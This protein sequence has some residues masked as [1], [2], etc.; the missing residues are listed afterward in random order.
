MRKKN[1]GGV[2]DLL[3]AEERFQ[4]VLE[5]A[6]RRDEAEVERL[7]NTSP[8]YRYTFIRNDLAFAERIGV[9]T[10]IAL[11]VCLMLMEILAKL[12]VIRISQECV[13]LLSRSL[14]TEFDRGYLRGLGSRLRARLAKRRH[15]RT[16]PVERQRRPGSESR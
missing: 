4:L 3:T 12:M 6:A 11:C 15:G 14:V 10:Q 13:A 5:A 7:A 16:V 8:R 9:S 1:L 2:Y